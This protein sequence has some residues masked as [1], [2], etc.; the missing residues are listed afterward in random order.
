[1]F[2]DQQELAG[3]EDLN[4]GAERALNDVAL[5]IGFSMMVLLF[6]VVSSMT[7]L[8]NIAVNLPQADPAPAEKRPS[9]AALTVVVSLEATDGKLSAAYAD[10]QP[11]QLDAS[12]DAMLARRYREK[13]ADASAVV[14]QI[15]ADGS[16]SH[17]AVSEAVFRFHAAFRSL[18]G[19]SRKVTVRYVARPTD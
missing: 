1:M 14:L 6:V 11:L 16:L 8:Q 5:S 18:G 9:G 4:V 19:A 13:L 17:A 12:L 2:D 3:G 10:D 15:R 7:A